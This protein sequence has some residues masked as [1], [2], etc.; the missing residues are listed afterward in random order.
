MEHLVRP[1]ELPEVRTDLQANPEL[2]PA[3]HPPGAP[4]Y[5]PP[6]AVDLVE[7]HPQVAKAMEV[8]G[9]RGN[10]SVPE[11]HVYDVIMQSLKKA[12]SA[13]GIAYDP[14]NPTDVAELK[15]LA[16]TKLDKTAQKFFLGK[17][18]DAGVLS[19][20]L[21]PEVKI[22]GL[23]TMDNYRLNADGTLSKGYGNATLE[24]RTLANLAQFAPEGAGGGP[25][26]LRHAKVDTAAQW[27]G[28]RRLAA[29][30]V[31]VSMQKKIDAGDALAPSIS[32]YDQK[33]PSWVNGH[34]KK[35]A[36]TE[37]LAAQESNKNNPDLPK[38]QTFAMT[39]NGLA[40]SA[41]HNLFIKGAER[42]INEP[43]MR[44]KAMRAL[45]EMVRSENSENPEVARELTQKFNAYEKSGDSEELVQFLAANPAMSFSG[46]L[47]D[48]VQGKKSLESIGRNLRQNGTRLSEKG[49]ALH[50][51]L[52]SLL[53]GK[54][55]QGKKLSRSAELAL[56]TALDQS[57]N[58]ISDA[59]C[60]SGQDRTLHLFA[61]TLAGRSLKD[62]GDKKTSAF[63]QNF[64]ALAKAYDRMENPSKLRKAFSNEASRKAAFEKLAT[65]SGLTPEDARAMMEKYRQT[66]YEAAIK[67]GLPMTQYSTLL[68]GLKWHNEKGGLKGFF[69]ENRLPINYMPKQIKLS[70]GE[71]VDIMTRD[72]FGRRVF[73]PDGI[74][75]IKGL[76]RFRKT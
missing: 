76:S 74:A 62:F 26:V 47:L 22:G 4:S 36:E 31:E 34:E 17:L 11:Q 8:L 2:G 38:V 58:V 51:N 18:S 14:T 25:S 7:P 48:V 16:A 42:R 56:H 59:G 39:A 61:M 69:Q 12:H 54:N 37:R 63:L 21:R 32:R 68:P 9:E 49:Q 53:L 66:Y 29:G 65:S 10:M 75:L 1:R 64:D 57:I 5:S 19:Q 41:I 33:T 70:N 30:K 44:D 23:G 20:L 43:A 3:N 73:T 40:D 52:T 46:H 28:I 15:K 13:E 67:T 45:I 24:E 35:M 6:V 60:K 50:D 72:A 27:D 55:T 71:A